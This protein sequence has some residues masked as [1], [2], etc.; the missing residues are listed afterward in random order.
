MDY[1]HQERWQNDIVLF[2]WLFHQ[3][4]QVAQL[5][6]TDR[7]AG[8]LVMTKSGRLEVGDNIYGYYKSIFNHCYVFGQQSNQIRWKPQKRLLRRSRS[9]KVIEVGTNRKP[10]CDFLVINSNWQPTVSRTVAE[11]SQL[12]VHI[13]DTLRF[14]ATLW[15]WGLG[16]M[17]DVHLGLIGKRVV[18][19]LLVIIELFFARCYGWGAT[20]ENRSKIGD[21][22]STWSVWPKISGI[23]GDVPTNNVAW[24]VRPINALQLCLGQFSHKETL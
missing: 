22:A 3:Y 17:Y 18:D 7:V 23:E 5:S 8:G 16:T 10:V 9:F 14:W 13:L 6:Q 1:K 12:M 15:G 4:R 2:I 11:F 19:F 21:F 20:G 24:I